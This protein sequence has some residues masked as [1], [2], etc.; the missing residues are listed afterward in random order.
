MKIWFG[1]LRPADEG[2]ETPLV[3]SRRVFK[4]LNE[5]IRDRFVEKQVMYVRNYGEG[6]GLSWRT[7]FRTSNKAEVEQKCR[8]NGMTFEWKEGDG[9]RTR[10]VRPAAIEHPLTGEISWFNQAQHWHIACLEP[11]V[12]DSLRSLLAEDNLPRNCYYG[13]GSPIADSTMEEILDVYQRLEI[14]FP[15]R[16]GDILLVDNV[17]TAHGRHPFLGERKL[18]VAMGEMR[19]YENVRAVQP[20]SLLQ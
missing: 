3:D 13:D 18:L 20:A 14:R 16:K 7:V 4:L 9:L 2:G 19:S 17:L 6:P 12:R 5:K 8:Q 10:C 1:C 11:A 15:W